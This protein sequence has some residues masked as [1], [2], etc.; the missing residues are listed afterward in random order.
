MLARRTRP[1]FRRITCP[2][3][4]CARQDVQREGDACAKVE[5]AKAMLEGQLMGLKGRFDNDSPARKRQRTG[6]SGPF[7]GS[8]EPSE[9]QPRS[10][11]PHAA[12]VRID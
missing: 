5:V 4:S 11:T 9:T 10:E 1:Q 6:S 8:E 7:G 12:Y 3:V 2:M